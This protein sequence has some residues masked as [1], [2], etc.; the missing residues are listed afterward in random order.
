MKKRRRVP[1]SGTATQFGCLPSGWEAMWQ[2]GGVSKPKSF[3]GLH[4][5]LPRSNRLIRQLN[6][7]ALGAWTNRCSVTKVLMLPAADDKEEDNVV[8]KKEA[9][10][11]DGYLHPWNILIKESHFLLKVNFDSFVIFHL[12]FSQRT[13][14]FSWIL[15]WHQW[16]IYTSVHYLYLHGIIT[17]QLFWNVKTPYFPVTQFENDLMVVN[18]T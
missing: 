6:S 4:F 9:A 2:F 1:P 5:V 11:L 15:Y 10:L 12:Q 16:K 13:N 7:Q 18:S 14:R 3:K 8:P 17:V